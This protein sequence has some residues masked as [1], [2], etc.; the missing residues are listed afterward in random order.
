M[1]LIK[2]KMNSVDFVGFT[3]PGY[4]LSHLKIHLNFSGVISLK[5]SPTLCGFLLYQP[6]YCCEHIL[7]AS[8]IW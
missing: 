8:W 1:L 4:V 2:N 3:A 6:A 5:E 7:I